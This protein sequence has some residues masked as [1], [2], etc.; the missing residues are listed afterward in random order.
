MGAPTL[1][2]SRC[3][4][5]AEMLLRQ[6]NLYLKAFGTSMLPSIWPGDVAQVQSCTFAEVELGDIVLCRREGGFQLHRVVRKT[7]HPAKL[8]TRGD[9]MPSC[10]TPAKPQE[11]L[12]KTQKIIRK[13]NIVASWRTPPFAKRVLGRLLAHSDL[14][15]RITLRLRGEWERLLA[16]GLRSSWHP[17]KRDSL[18]YS[19]IADKTRSN[20]V[21][22][23]ERRG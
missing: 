18:P 14:C 7:D 3:D 9:A 22:C 17:S 21:C 1:E 4:F 6:G 13:E 20:L 8:V 11:I 15:L 10:D 12:G 19:G 23:E 5:A 2:Q 16:D